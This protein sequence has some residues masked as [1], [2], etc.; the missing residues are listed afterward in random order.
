MVVKIG[1]ASDFNISIHDICEFYKNNWLN[2]T[3]LLEPNFYSWQ[4]INNP[5]KNGENASCVALLNDVIVGVMG[6]NE[7]DFYLNGNRQKGAELTTWIINESSR[8]KGIAQA[9]VDFI[10]DKYEMISGMGVSKA[11]LNVY[12]KK[13]IKYFKGIPR[14][15][16]V[17]NWDNVTKYMQIEPLG[18]KYAERQLHHIYSVSKNIEEEE[19]NKIFEKFKKEYNVFSR[20]SHDLKWRYKDHPIFEYDIQIVEWQ[21]Y[22]C[23]VCLRIDRKIDGL[24]MA[25]CVDIFG[26]KEAFP[27]ALSYV[28]DAAREQGADVVDLFCTNPALQ[29]AAKFNGWFSTLD[30]DFFK[31]PHLFHPIEMR[32][33]A[34]TSFII[35]SKNNFYQLLDLGKLHLT[36]QDADFD[37]PTLYRKIRE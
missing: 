37:R 16:S 23:L 14:F 24:V 19:V 22:V 33:P 32:E 4:F 9:I 1:S 30:D 18:R 15:I 7:R 6:I 12:L 8:G 5:Y 3:A 20:Y 35:W 34:T 27:S 28:F 10:Q 17:I 11:A 13:G 25:H 29:A 2:P 26:D 21:G 36:K 31:F